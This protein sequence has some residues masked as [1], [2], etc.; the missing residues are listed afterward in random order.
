VAAHETPLPI[1]RQRGSVLG[2]REWRLVRHRESGEYGVSS[3]WSPDVWEGP[4]MHADR[5]PDD[6]TARGMP[7]IHAWRPEH[8]MP[9]SIGFQVRG[10]VLLHGRIVCHE[11]GYRAEH[12]LIRDLC[13]VYTPRTEAGT[14]TLIPGLLYDIMEDFLLGEHGYDEA[15]TGGMSHDEA[16]AA[17]RSLERRYGCDIACRELTLEELEEIWASE[18]P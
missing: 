4:A 18:T 14:L 2:W 12:A 8:A 17:A 13:L 11:R 15:L 5:R 9:S 6:P 10:H 3:L 7:G 1:R 16:R